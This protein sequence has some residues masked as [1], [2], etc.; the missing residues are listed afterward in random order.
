MDIRAVE[1]REVGSDNL[2][3]E[4][5]MK[6]KGRKKHNQNERSKNNYVS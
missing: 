6:P 4:M 5:K 2:Q 1:S 3:L